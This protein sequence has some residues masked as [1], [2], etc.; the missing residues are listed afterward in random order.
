MQFWSSFK[1]WF[2]QNSFD[3]KD[4]DCNYNPIYLTFLCWSLQFLQK[5]ES[6][7]HLMQLFIFILAFLSLQITSSGYSVHQ[8]AGKVKNSIFLSQ[9]FP[10]NGFRFRILEN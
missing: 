5:Y 9:F 2:K 6:N 7:M 10:K 3:K 8:L 4:F 1:V